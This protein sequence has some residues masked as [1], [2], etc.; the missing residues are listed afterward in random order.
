MLLNAQS[1]ERTELRIMRK[2]AVKFRFD[3]NVVRMGV[4]QRKFVLGRRTKDG[5]RTRSIGRKFE[6]DRGIPRL[7][8]N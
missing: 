3:L 6:V 5:E 8:F 1:G 7:E 2:D 4:G